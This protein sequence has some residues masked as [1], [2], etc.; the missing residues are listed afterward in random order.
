MKKV[1]EK[2]KLKRYLYK[3]YE[4]KRLALKVLQRLPSSNPAYSELTRYA[5]I[6]LARLPRNSAKSRIRNRCILTG[7]GNSVYR[8]FRI[9]RIEVRKLA[10]ASSGS[11]R[12][13]GSSFKLPYVKK[14][15]W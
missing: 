7:R 12:T 9:S 2:D 1:V 3:K 11:S 14:A 5:G 4:Q 13:P 6:A 8:A 10:L 15:S